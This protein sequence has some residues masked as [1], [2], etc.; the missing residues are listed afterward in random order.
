MASFE[1]R[2]ARIFQRLFSGSCHAL[3]FFSAKIR[4]LRMK[5]RSS[6]ALMTVV[7]MY[8]IFAGTYGGGTVLCVGG[9]NGLALLSSGA[10][11]CALHMKAAI[12]DACCASDVTV[13][14]E[15]DVA[16]HDNGVDGTATA[17]AM[18]NPNDCLGCTDH[19]LR[20]Q[21]F[22]PPSEVSDDVA[23]PSPVMVT[24]LSWPVCTALFSPLDS[25]RNGERPP[26]LRIL[27]MWSTVILRC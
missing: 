2:S 17:L 18:M 20:T 4:E 26:S 6:V 23:I 10:N 19:E 7:L 25:R 14:C 24:T 8:Q 22:L 15:K 3:H 16:V 5:S 12:P 9:A 1:Y 27:Q 21:P 11:C 13:A